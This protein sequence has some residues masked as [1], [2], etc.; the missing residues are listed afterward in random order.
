MR[1]DQVGLWIGRDHKMHEG[2]DLAICIDSPPANATELTLA[3]TVDP[4]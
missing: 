2:D 4:E 3:E 1:A